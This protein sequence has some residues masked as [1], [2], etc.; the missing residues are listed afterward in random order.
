MAVSNRE[1]VGKALDL[2]CGGLVPFVER[3]LK[4]VHGA[5]WEEVAREGQPAERGKGKKATKLHWDTQA[6]LAVMW[7]QWNTVFNRTLSAAERSIVSELRDVRNKW[8]HQEA[9][10]SNDAY[11]A[12]QHRAF[13]HCRF[14]ARGRRN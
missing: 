12:G 4:A 1:R 3:E 7:N 10:A 8:A 9:F 13:A 2:L 6:L 11:R 14:R 5:K